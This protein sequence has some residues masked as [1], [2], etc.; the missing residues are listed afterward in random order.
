VND[1]SLFDLGFFGKGSLS[2][3][4]VDENAEPQ[5]LYLTLQEAFYLH[6][7][8]GC[9]SVLDPETGKHL[10]IS[11]FWKKC[12]EI[13]GESYFVSRYVVYHHFRSKGYVVRCGL[14]YGSD[15][16]IY[17]KGPGL[18]HALYSVN[19]VLPQDEHSLT[20]KDLHHHSRL[21]V[22]V[23]KVFLFLQKNLIFSQQLLLCL[24]QL[25][26]SN[27]QNVNQVLPQ[28]DI[29][30]CCITRFLPKRERE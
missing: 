15:Y 14:K 26:S 25:P 28:T 21:N 23:A 19:V 5:E 11:Q 10:N 16:V 4:S 27:L 2:Q 20:W 1:L 18:D 8:F 9:L 3:R 24:V 30:I 12:C 29:Q 7:A 13:E 17:K 22:T 6:Y